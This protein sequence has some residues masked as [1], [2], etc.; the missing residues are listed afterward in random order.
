MQT[1]SGEIKAGPSLG[2]VPLFAVCFIL[3]PSLRRAA[4]VLSCAGQEPSARI[5]SSGAPCRRSLSPAI[6]S[7]PA[8]VRMRC[9]M[10]RTACFVQSGRGR[11]RRNNGFVFRVPAGSGF[12]RQD[13]KAVP[14]FQKD[15]AGKEKGE[16][17]YLK[18]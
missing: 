10:M 1:R 17:V 12:L 4:A 6:R 9:A 15:D 14:L 5:R 8:M 2:K 13:G 7:A 11:G 18:T 3:A 16:M